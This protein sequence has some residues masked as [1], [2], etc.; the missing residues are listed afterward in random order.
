[1]SRREGAVRTSSR[2]AEASEQLLAFSRGLYPILLRADTVAF[3]SYL[4]RWEDVIGDTSELTATPPDQLRRTMVAL[5]RRPQQF[6]LPPWPATPAQEQAPRATPA[7][8][9]E[10]GARQYPP[11]PNGAPSP[12]PSAVEPAPP[13]ESP[14]PAVPR[15]GTYQVDML[16]GELVPVLPGAPDGAPAGVAEAPPAPYVAAE[17]AQPP[18]RRRRPR[19]PPRGMKQLTF[20]PSLA[21]AD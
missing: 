2:G 8:W 11:A 13:P 5:L 6:G 15:R 20:L 16:T 3:S 9:P 7:A 10:K 19:R 4:S 21:S 17:E 1:M 14:P 18:P 12:A